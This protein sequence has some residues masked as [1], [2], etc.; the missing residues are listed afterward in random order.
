LVFDQYLD[1]ILHELFSHLYDFW[2]HGG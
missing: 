2:R 1:R